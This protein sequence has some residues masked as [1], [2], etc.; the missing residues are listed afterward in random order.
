MKEHI[1][2]D[3]RELSDGTMAN[4]TGINKYDYVEFIVA[5][6]IEFYGMTL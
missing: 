3:C 4:L 6:S 5:N 1:I 2:A